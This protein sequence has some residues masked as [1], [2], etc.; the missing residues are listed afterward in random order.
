MPRIPRKKSHNG[1]YHIMLRGINRQTIFEDDEDRTRLLD[2]IK[3]YK[4]ISRIKIFGFCLMDN[5][6]HLLIKETEEPISNAIQRI[7]ASYVYWY[8]SKY[9]RCGHLFQDRFKSENVETE[10][11]FLRVLRY[12]HQNPVKAGLAKHAF[13]WKW[14]SIHEYI[15]N[16]NVVD[17]EVGLS[18]FSTNRREAVKLFSEFMQMPNDDQYLDDH[19]KVKVSDSV[20]R[21]YLSQVGIA[22]SSMLQQLDREKRNAII[23]ELKEWKGVS[24]RQIARI[25]GISKS[26]IDRVR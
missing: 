21:N 24:V 7:S 22:N 3:K 6:V 13:D 14:T 1:M 11:S 9:E 23:V 19:I 25:T 20:V 17:I 16:S 18:L 12:I 26:V 2:T 15:S 5:H 4:E 8:N 10:G